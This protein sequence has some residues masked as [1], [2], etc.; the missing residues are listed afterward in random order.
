MRE[1]IVI[2][3]T[4]DPVI[5][6]AHQHLAARGFALRSVKPFH[7]EPLPEIGDTTAGVI[8]MGGPQMVRLLFG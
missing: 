5:D 6:R 2:E 7:G 4:D 1:I 3:H 8:I